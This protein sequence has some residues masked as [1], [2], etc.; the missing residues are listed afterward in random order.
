MQEGNRRGYNDPTL[1]PAHIRVETE[2]RH[3]ELNAGQRQAVAE[4]FLSREKIVGLDGIAGAGKTTTLAVVREGAES[5]GYKVEGFAPTSRA[6]Q[7]LGDAGIETMTSGIGTPASDKM[8]LHP[9]YPPV[10]TRSSPR[11]CGQRLG[12]ERGRI[13]GMGKENPVLVSC[14]LH[15]SSGPADWHSAELDLR[16]QLR[17]LTRRRVQ[18]TQ[19]ATRERN[20]VQK[21]LEQVNVKIGSVLTE[22]RGFTLHI[23]LRR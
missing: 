12:Q 3:P 13:L 7:T 20:R 18:L 23:H 9:E 8:R 21:L 17:D 11:T 16:G 6:A 4:V 22:H 10:G 14:S 2:D 1:V 19:D 15:C 5:A